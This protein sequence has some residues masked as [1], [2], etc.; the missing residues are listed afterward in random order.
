MGG[1]PIGGPPIGGPPIGG[2]A[3]GAGLGNIAGCG[4]GTVRSKSGIAA[5]SNKH[6]RLW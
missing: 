2:P 5:A 3:I 4:C 6:V 1:P